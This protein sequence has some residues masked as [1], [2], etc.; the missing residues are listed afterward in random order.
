MSDVESDSAHAEKMRSKENSIS[1]AF[2]STDQPSNGFVYPPAE[3]SDINGVAVTSSKTLSLSKDSSASNCDNKDTASSDLVPELVKFLRKTASERLSTIPMSELRNQL[4]L[5]SVQLPQGH[6]FNSGVSDKAIEEAVLA[7]GG[8]RL[9][10]QWSPNCR[11][12]PLYAFYTGDEKE[13]M[14]LKCLYTMFEDT[15]R[16]RT[17][18]YKSTLQTMTGLE[19]SGSEIMTFLKT[20]CQSAAAMWHLKGVLNSSS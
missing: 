12:Q 1:K 5:Y 8:I 6:I 9:N 3:V 2:S 17:S 16:I 20:H 4:A 15:P 7:Y 14:L 11:P 10:Y 13:N 19:L 18:S